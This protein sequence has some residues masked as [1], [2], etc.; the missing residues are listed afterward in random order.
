MVTDNYTNIRDNFKKE[1][2]LARMLVFE[3]DNEE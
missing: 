3:H 1:G 2:K